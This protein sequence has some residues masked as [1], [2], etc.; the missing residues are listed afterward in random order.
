MIVPCQGAMTQAERFPFVSIFETAAD[1][2]GFWL[3]NVGDS[4]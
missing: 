1:F 2:I 4:C 3:A